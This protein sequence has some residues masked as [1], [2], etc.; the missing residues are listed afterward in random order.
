MHPCFTPQHRLARGKTG[1]Q[2]TST[3]QA[4]E[5]SCWGAHL[6]LLKTRTQELNTFLLFP[7][8]DSLRK[9]LRKALWVRAGL[10]CWAGVCVHMEIPCA[11]SDFSGY[12]LNKTPTLPSKLHFTEHSLFPG[13]PSLDTWWPRRLFNLNIKQEMNA[14]FCH[15]LSRLYW[16]SHRIKTYLSKEVKI[17]DDNYFIINL[18]T[19]NIRTNLKLNHTALQNSIYLF[20]SY[21]RYLQFKPHWTSIILNV[22]KSILCKYHMT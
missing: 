12:F 6:G 8:A 9:A 20:L 1:T 13:K 15:R 4:E 18:A 19:M 16:M 2:H 7:W 10:L 14:N 11:P 5:S 22:D 17:D 21:Y 3:K